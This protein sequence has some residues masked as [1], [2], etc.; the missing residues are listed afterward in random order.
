MYY[1]DSTILK[2]SAG[3]WIEN[4]SKETRESSQGDPNIYEN[5]MY[6]ITYKVSQARKL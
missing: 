6:K 1:K 2:C 3:K 4:Q 5:F